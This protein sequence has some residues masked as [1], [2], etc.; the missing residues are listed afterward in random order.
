M[1]QCATLHMEKQFREL[2]SI[3]VLQ[4]TL[5]SKLASG[6]D[7]LQSRMLHG[8]VLLL[9]WCTAASTEKFGMAK[10]TLTPLYLEK[11]Q[12]EAFSFFPSHFRKLVSG[13]AVLQ[14][15]TSLTGVAFFFWSMIN[16]DA[17]FLFQSSQNWHLTLVMFKKFFLLL[18][19]S[20]SLQFAKKGLKT[21]PCVHCASWIRP[22]F[23]LHTLQ[24]ST[25]NH[26]TH[27]SFSLD[28]AAARA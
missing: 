10:Q 22:F 18:S 21:L 20:F 7:V 17:G 24:F 3:P 27:G 4:L 9:L 11:S 14:S 26:L 2:L 5:L 13:S 23:S 12:A 28:E 1:R 16:S 8:A 6:S 15:R 25:E 19:H